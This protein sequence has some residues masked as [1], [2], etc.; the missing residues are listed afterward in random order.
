MVIR[1]EG[2]QVLLAHRTHPLA[3]E[4]F[5]STTATPCPEPTQT[6]ATP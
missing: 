2:W 5:S 4:G 3:A 6:P 1:P